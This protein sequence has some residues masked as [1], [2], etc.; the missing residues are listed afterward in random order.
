MVAMELLLAA[1]CAFVYCGQR[2]SP[3]LGNGALECPHIRCTR[4]VSEHINDDDAGVSVCSG[5]WLSL[6]IRDTFKDGSPCHS[7]A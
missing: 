4:D 7:R 2:P 6:L 5:G 3:P 1:D